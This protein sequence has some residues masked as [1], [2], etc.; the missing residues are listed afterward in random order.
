MEKICVHC[1]ISGRV[2]G[3]GFRHYAKKQATKQQV[4]GWVK[5]L[6]D[7]R[8]EIFAGGELANINEFISWLHRGPASADVIAVVCKSEPWQEFTDFSIIRAMALE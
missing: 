7:G 6:A 4:T 2:Q 3:V 1:Y 5:N 8:V